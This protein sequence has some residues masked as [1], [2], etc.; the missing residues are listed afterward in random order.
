MPAI[1]DIDERHATRRI[2][3]FPDRA[4]AQKQKRQARLQRPHERRHLLQHGARERPANLARIAATNQR[5]HGKLLQLGHGIQ[6]PVA[7]RQE[8]PEEPVRERQ[9]GARRP[10][11]RIAPPDAQIEEARQPTEEA[12]GE[13]QAVRERVRGGR[14]RLQ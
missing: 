6:Q 10:H 12:L 4:G 3:P 14:R 13:L 5:V 1:P 9:P 7:E 11:G 8:H 2:R